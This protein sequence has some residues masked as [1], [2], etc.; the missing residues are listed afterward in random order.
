MKIKTRLGVFTLKV[1]HKVFAFQIWE[2]VMEDVD[3]WII[4]CYWF[5]DAFFTK[6]LG[7]LFV[8]LQYNFLTANI[9]IRTSV[10][11]TFS[12]QYDALD[13]SIS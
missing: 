11:S 8:R 10:P 3:N 6:S 4:V 12:Q 2:K 7:A 9:D 1:Q 5:S 13:I